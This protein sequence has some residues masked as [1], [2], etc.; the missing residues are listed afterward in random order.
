MWL[1]KHLKCLAL[2]SLITKKSH[3]IVLMAVCD[4]HYNFILVD[5]SDSGRNSDGGVFA[6]SRMGDTFVKKK[7][8]IPNAEALPGTSMR[9]LYVLVAD[10]AFQLQQNLMK[11]YPR[12]VLGI[13]ERVFNYRLSRARRIIE[14]TFGIAAAR[15]RVFRFP[16]HARVEMVVNV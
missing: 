2:L 15:F 7:L 16:I 4:A 12:E 1:C 3:S 13:R 9:Y 11:P 6:S 5:I 8:H 14:N 10:E